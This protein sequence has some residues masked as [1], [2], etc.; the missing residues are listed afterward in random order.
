MRKASTHALVG[1]LMLAGCV[2]RPWSPRP[3]GAISLPVV[4]QQGA[5]PA[6]TVDVA[7]PAPVPQM[8]D[9]N[10]VRDVAVSCLPRERPVGRLTLAFRRD[11][12]GNLDVRAE[13]VKG[14]PRSVVAC[15]V[16][17]LAGIEVVPFMRDQE[18]AAVPWP[19]GDVVRIPLM[20]SPPR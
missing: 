18:L 8:L 16:S 1:S 3:S 15:I 12:E 2:P 9:P 5:P 20:F 10:T 19:E 17:G 13:G 6:S 11:T 4:R 7:P 14:L